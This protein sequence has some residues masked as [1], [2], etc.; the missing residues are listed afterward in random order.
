MNPLDLQVLF[1]QQ[2][3]VARLTQA[4]Q[5]AAA[6]VQ[7][8]VARRIVRDSIQSEREI[9]KAREGRFARAEDRERRGKNFRLGRRVDIVVYQ[10]SKSQSKIDVIG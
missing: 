8:G 3:E 5:V 2:G 9:S 7:E 4:Q 1:Q 10:T 6:A